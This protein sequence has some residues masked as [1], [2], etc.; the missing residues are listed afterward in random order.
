M[1]SSRLFLTSR[2]PVPVFADLMPR[3]ILSRWRLFLRSCCK[4]LRKLPPAR[5]TCV[6]LALLGF[7]S[8]DV[9]WTQTLQLSPA[10]ILQRA[11]PGSIPVT[12]SPAT[13]ATAPAG[14]D[15]SRVRMSQLLVPMQKESPAV[16]SVASHELLLRAGVVR[17]A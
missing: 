6:W 8:T 5:R 11:R 4:A 14:P 3:V 2:L 15:F 12:S 1:G 7:A 13:E 17:Q 16:A 10:D 9:G